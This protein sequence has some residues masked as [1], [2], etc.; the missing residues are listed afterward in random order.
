[1]HH[2]ER[3]SARVDESAAL[4]SQNTLSAVGRL[5][6]VLCNERKSCYILGVYMYI[7][8]HI[9]IYIYTHIC[10][11]KDDD[12]KWLVIFRVERLSTHCFAGSSIALDGWWWFTH[13][14]SCQWISMVYSQFV[15]NFLAMQLDIAFE[16]TTRKLLCTITVYLYTYKYKYRYKY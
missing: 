12:P 3:R 1:M 8:I 4:A 15:Y 5:G 11:M 16:P 10:P 6:G 9:H 7:Y 14:L 13:I 2:V